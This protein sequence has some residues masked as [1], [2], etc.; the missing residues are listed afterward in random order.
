MSEFEPNPP[1]E[2]DPKI[3]FAVEQLQG[4]MRAL[5][6]GDVA[7]AFSVPLYRTNI[8][9]FTALAAALGIGDCPIGSSGTPITIQYDP[10]TGDLHYECSHSPPH[11][12]NLQGGHKTC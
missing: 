12:W 9:A 11:C 2:L 5:Q 6:L 1:L 3:M 10:A 8:T 4:A 7:R